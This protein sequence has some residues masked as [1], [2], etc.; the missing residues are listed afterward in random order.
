M[1]TFT[2]I[3]LFLALPLAV[4]RL[5]GAVILTK[6]TEIYDANAR[7]NEEPDGFLKLTLDF[8]QDGIPEFVIATNLYSVGILH[9]IGNRIFIRSDPPPNIGGSAASIIGGAEI[10]GT[11]E[12]TSYRWYGGGFFYPGSF[13]ENLSETVR[14]TTIGLA[15]DTGSLGHTRG[16]DGYLGFE[17]TLE[18]G[19]HYA[20]VHF[21]ASAN[22]RLADG[23]IFGI[24]GYIDGWAWETT[25]G[26]GIL[27]GA[28]PEPSVLLLACATLGSW[29]FFRR[30]AE[31]LVGSHRRPS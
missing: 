5:Q 9:D 11:S 16:K 29:M 19:L 21:D 1:K 12:N 15:F 10:A 20:W 14:Y 17:F 7:N 23:T 25:P 27:A 30:R 31:E 2:L 8:N 24:G 22:A 28:V 13:G 6:L 18:D 4:G 3:V 26:K